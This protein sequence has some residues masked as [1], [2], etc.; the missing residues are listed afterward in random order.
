M[1]PDVSA[2]VY[3]AVLAGCG[4]GVFVLAVG[5]ALRVYWAGGPP[6]RVDMVLFD[7]DRTVAVYALW[8]TV[9]STV[10]LIIPDFWRGVA[11]NPEYPPLFWMGWLLA[12]F[13]F[14]W[15]RHKAHIGQHPLQLRDR[16][17][18]REDRW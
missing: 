13:T 6:D 15:G 12:A 17:T 11:A 14:L 2:T 8:I 10:A 3:C 16:M 5:M 1:R 18:R 4:F 7:V 9:I